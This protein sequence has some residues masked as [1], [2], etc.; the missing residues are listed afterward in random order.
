[1][2]PGKWMLVRWLVRCCSWRLKHE[3][4]NAFKV[5]KVNATRFLSK[6]TKINFG[7][8]PEK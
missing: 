2:R 6:K 3:C 4:R 8:I 1:M 5:S 7:N